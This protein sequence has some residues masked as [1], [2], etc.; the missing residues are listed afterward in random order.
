MA[1]AN[2][3]VMRTNIPT[4]AEIMRRL[5]VDARGDVQKHVTD[6]VFRRLIPYIPLKTGALRSKADIAS[7]TKI[8]V[9]GVYAR[10]Q[11]FGVTRKGVPF[12]YQPTG[13]KVGSHWD[14]R[15]IADEGRAI[16]A[17]ATRYAMRKHVRL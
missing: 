15:L 8:T 10:A 4:N 1:N 12:N 5:G 11:F 13:A 6:E 17:D 2:R 7:N 16:A 3:S 14:R 9:S